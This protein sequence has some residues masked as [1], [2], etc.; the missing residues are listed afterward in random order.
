MGLRAAS[1]IASSRQHCPR[2]Q[3]RRRVMLARPQAPARR[4]S[5]NW[6]ALLPTVKSWRGAPRCRKSFEECTP[7]E[8]TGHTAGSTLNRRWG[9]RTLPSSCRLSFILTCSRPVP[10]HVLE[11]SPPE[12]AIALTSVYGAVMVVAC[13]YGRNLRINFWLGGILRLRNSPPIY[14][15]LYTLWVMGYNRVQE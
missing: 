9:F 1:E 13:A 4:P 11:W 7:G 2:G 14:L 3:L 10:D 15:A 6:S 8:R 5:D 12:Q